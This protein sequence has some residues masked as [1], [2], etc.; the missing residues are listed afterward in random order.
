MRTA[1]PIAALGLAA[2]LLA[3]PAFAQDWAADKVTCVGAYGALAQEVPAHVAWEPKFGQGTNLT[4]I[5]WAS[6]RTK[7]LAGGVATEAA[8]KV[9][10]DNFRQM[11]RKDRID[12]VAKGTGVVIE[13]SMRCDTAFGYAPSFVIPP[14]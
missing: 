14:K 10:E 6:R 8:A 11:L 3:A 5:D 12:D 13:L 1:A 7:L 9:Y 2:S 4:T